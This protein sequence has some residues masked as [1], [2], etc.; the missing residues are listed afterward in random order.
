MLLNSQFKQLSFIELNISLI[1]H[2]P[3]I[4]SKQDDIH[5]VQV[6]LFVSP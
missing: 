4:I 3:L 2:F 1:M 6:I 5:E